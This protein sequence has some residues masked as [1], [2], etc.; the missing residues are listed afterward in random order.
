MRRRSLI[1]IASTVGFVAVLGSPAQAYPDRPVTIVVPWA[2]GG[3]TDATARII[4]SV[5][6]KE[7]GKPVNVVNRTGGSGVV[8]HSAIATARPDGY[9]LGLIT[10]E[11]N[12]MH[13]QGLTDIT[14][15]DYTPLAL[16]NFDPAGV[17]V[18]A[19]SPYKTA[20]DLVDAL[21][22]APKGQFKASGTGQGGIWHVALGALLEK[23]GL[24][25]DHVQWVP[26]QGAAP[27]LQDMVA[28]GVDLVTCSVPEAKSLMEAGKVR[29]L[30]LMA[31]ERNPAFPDV[32]TI[33]EAVGVEVELGAWRGMAGPEGLPDE[34]TSVLE[35]ALKRA[36][37]DGDFQDFMK[38]QGYGV[39][40]ADADGF[41]EFMAENDERFGG[42][43]K[44]LGLAQ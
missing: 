23:L 40:Y 33:A 4:G 7:L 14:Y 12:M 30:A 43:M 31:S 27:G 28:G 37:D 44:G 2:A 1:A 21:K 29:A 36:Y 5:L 11:T 39:I 32:P 20:Q 35:P 34:V 15:Q 24:P 9:T 25:A 3:G 17:I 13:W 38:K 19:D 22:N 6:E 18:R 26:S 16:M 10:V 42:I 41:K 8:G